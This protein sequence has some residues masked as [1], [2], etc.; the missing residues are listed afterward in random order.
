MNDVLISFLLNIPTDACFP[1]PT[2]C[3]FSRP[4]AVPGETFLLFQTQ[5]PI[6]ISFRL[7]LFI[8]ISS[9]RHV[10]SAKVSPL[11]FYQLHG[12]Y[13][14][15]IA[16]ESSSS[17]R[18]VQ[19]HADLWFV[20]WWWL[21]SRAFCTKWGRQPDSD[22]LTCVATKAGL[23]LRGYLSVMPTL[24]D[25]RMSSSRRV[26]QLKGVSRLSSVDLICLPIHWHCYVSYA[27]SQ[28]LC[29]HIKAM[30]L[31]SLANTP[32]LSQGKCCLRFLQG[33]GRPGVRHTCL[34]PRPFH[35]SRY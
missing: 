22:S 34:L 26:L 17:V 21:M 27:C 7:L 12:I 35:Y 32:D 8:Q 10:S 25:S 1:L 15:K 28:G 19:S 2:Q 20:A 14:K 18:T 3:P 31:K 11:N 9:A 29:K 16:P 23:E 13:L 4:F 30:S 33:E 6:H 24:S 5:M